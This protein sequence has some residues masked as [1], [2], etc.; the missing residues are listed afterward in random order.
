MPHRMWRPNVGGAH[1]TI[2]VRWSPWAFDGELV[3]D[4]TVIKTWGS[5]ISGPDIDFQI[6]G[7]PAFIRN[8]LTDFDLFV[9]GEK[10]AS[11]KE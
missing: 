10:V 9:D 6:E 5:R 11:I 3:L 2:V 8:T 4:G 7:H 1:H